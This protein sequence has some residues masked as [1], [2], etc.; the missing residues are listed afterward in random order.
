A[1]ISEESAARI[2]DPFFTTKKGAANYGLGLN[3]CYGVMQKHGGSI[4]LVE[5]G[6]GKGTWMELRFPAKRV[7]MMKIPDHSAA[8][9][10]GV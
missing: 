5:T 9:R 7:R 8:L 1:G 10:I 3:Y 6:Q 2:F 4:R